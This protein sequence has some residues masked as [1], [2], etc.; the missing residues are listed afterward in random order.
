MKKEHTT[1]LQLKGIDF[2]KLLHLFVQIIFIPV[3]AG[4]L[5]HNFQILLPLPIGVFIL[6]SIFSNFVVFVP[7]LLENRHNL[8]ISVE[9][10]VM[11]IKNCRIRKTESLTYDLAN[12]SIKSGQTHESFLWAFVYMLGFAWNLYFFNEGIKL[13]SVKAFYQGLPMFFYGLFTVILYLLIWFLPDKEFVVK[14]NE[15]HKEGI[16]LL[17]PSVCISFKGKKIKIEKHK[18]TQLHSLLKSETRSDSKTLMAILKEN[19]VF[20]FQ[21]CTWL[22]VWLFGATFTFDFFHYQFVAA[23][24]FILLVYNIR[25]V[26]TTKTGLKSNPWW[27]YPFWILTFHEVG[28]KVW[29]LTA[30]GA[31]SPST[32]IWTLPVSWILYIL[33]IISIILEIFTNPNLKRTKNTAQIVLVGIFLV[34]LLLQVTAIFSTYQ[35]ISFYLSFIEIGPLI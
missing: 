28:I 16:I 14:N 32:I 11:T 19:W 8:E 34:E 1:T 20:I 13:L 35:F 29:H 22:V 2:I 4:C 6:V 25:S 5:E 12:Y 17:V 21:T 31:M 27:I 18:I 33:V 26:L 23:F 9:S 30:L 15:N 3:A 7:H 10:Q 24:V